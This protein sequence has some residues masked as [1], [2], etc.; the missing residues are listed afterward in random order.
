MSE[1]TY[2]E[3]SKAAQEEMRFK[4]PMARKII[5]DYLEARQDAR[6]KQ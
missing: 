1:E 2:A 3:L 4:T 6:D 5:C